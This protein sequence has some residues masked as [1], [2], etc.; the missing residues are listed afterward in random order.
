MAYGLHQFRN[1]LGHLRRAVRLKP[2]VRFLWR[3]LVVRQEVMKRYQLRG[4]GQPLHLRHRTQDL[5]GFTEVFVR[6]NYD[7]PPAIEATLQ[8]VPA[9]LRAVDLGAN[10]GLFGVRLLAQT[11]DAE[12][13][14]VEPDPANAEVLEATIARS[15]AVARWSVI[16]ACAGITDG[17]VPFRAGGF[18]ESRV[19]DDGIPFPAIDIFPVLRSADVIKIDI[20]G[21]ERAILADARFADLTAR[22]LSLEYHPPHT[23]PEITKLLASAGYSVEPFV[24]R[25]PG[26]GEL[27][28]WRASR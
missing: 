25:L 26:Y 3:E 14:A 23:R 8:E 10:I 1:G 4:T 20:E 11:P 27:W 19:A 7:F 17:T 9:P 12:I 18:L 13:I 15:D 28:A 24:E 16:Q 21:A 22:V 2:S 6:R 5:T